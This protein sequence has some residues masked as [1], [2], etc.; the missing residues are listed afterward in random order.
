MRLGVCSGEYVC[1]HM[2]VQ[3]NSQRPEEDVESVEAGVPGVFQDPW[4][5]K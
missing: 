4:L 2:G 1:T 5:V 3:A